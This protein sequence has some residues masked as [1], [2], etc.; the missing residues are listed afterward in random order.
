MRA[1]KMLELDA[2]SDSKVTVLV[3]VR[4]QDGLAN[5]PAF[6]LLPYLRQV[7]PMMN[8]FFPGRLTRMVVYPMPRA[9]SA[10]W[11][12]VKGFL[13]SSTAAKVLLLPGSDRAGS[14]VPAELL[15]FVAFEE[16][17]ADVQETHSA[18]ADL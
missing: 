11:G 1:Q 3:D 7:A 14:P 9:A 4:A 17:R 5:P 13:S 10:L 16:L 8:N 12:I 15:D 18:L 2:E 6:K